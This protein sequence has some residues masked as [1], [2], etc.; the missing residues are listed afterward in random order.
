[1]L[2][3]LTESVADHE[4]LVVDDSLFVIPHA[5]V[6]LQAVGVAEQALPSLAMPGGSKYATRDEEVVI[7]QIQSSG[8]F[9]PEGLLL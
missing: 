9:V 1:M 6:S 2:E 5:A 7:A 8:Q 4:S 3:V